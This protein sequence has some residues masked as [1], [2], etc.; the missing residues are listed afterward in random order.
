VTSDITA[1]FFEKV[2]SGT[3]FRSGHFANG[4]T[5]SSS[6]AKSRGADDMRSVKFFQVA[7]L[8]FRGKLAEAFSR[9]DGNHRLTATKDDAVRERIAPF[10]L[11]LCQNQVEFRRFSRSLFHNINYKQVPLTMEHNLQ[12]ILED[13]ELF[14]D[15][16][17]QKDPSYGWPY[18]HARKL[19]GKL[20]FDLL[21]NIKSFIETEPRTFLLRQFEFLTAKRVL[22]DNENAIKRFKEALGQVNGL[23]DTSPALKESTNCGLLAVLAYYQL[24]RPAK[25]PSF[26]RWVLA[27]HLHLIQN[28]SAPDLIAI[29]DKVLA[30]VCGARR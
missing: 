16:T 23:F 2:K 26:V 10:C 21:P 18:Y 4:V 29:F 1:A 5:I 14:P 9:L 15:E 7:T 19:H 12:L 6:V 3:P 25:V 20:D 8:S 22:G 17:L 30:H 13:D 28:S 11:I 27:N 24:A